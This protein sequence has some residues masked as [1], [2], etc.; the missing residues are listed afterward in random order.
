[1]G[2]QYDTSIYYPVHFVPDSISSTS[3]IIKTGVVLN[4]KGS[5]WEILKRNLSFKFNPLELPVSF[6]KGKNV[7]PAKKIKTYIS[8]KLGR[9]ELKSLV[10]DSVFLVTKATIQKKV[11][12]TLDSS[13][14]KI[15]T[16]YRISGKIYLEPDYITVTGLSNVVLKI[17]DTL[18]LLKGA[19]LNKSIDTL[20]KLTEVLPK[21]VKS[22]YRKAHLI[23][24]IAPF[25]KKERNVTA[26]LVGFP[27]NGKEMGVVPV[28]KV[29]Y[30]VEEDNI[31]VES[32]AK[33]KVILNY[34]MRDSI[35]KTLVPVLVDFPDYIRDYKVTPAL[36]SLKHVK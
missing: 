26:S 30:F 11:F 9:L 7:V 20:L 34:N 1:M 10:T 31:V 19:T 14:F 15:K 25:F 35:T 2:G 24:D 18:F 36:I 6:A 3:Q 12:L 33:Y 4:V 16:P 21:D 8:S 5:G 29:T 17:P 13:K 27:E 28:F 32:K 23:F 22:D